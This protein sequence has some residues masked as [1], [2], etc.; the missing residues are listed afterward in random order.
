MKEG[1]LTE[2]VTE[3]EAAPES[4]VKEEPD[5]TVEE[6]IVTEVIEAEAAPEPRVKEESQAVVE[7]AIVTEEVIEAQAA[8]K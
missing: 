2:E 7:E 5:A 1:I 3:A 4:A 8:Q 6:A